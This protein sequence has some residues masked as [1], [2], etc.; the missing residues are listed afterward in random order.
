M[1]PRPPLWL[2]SRGAGIRLHPDHVDSNWD[3]WLD[4]PPGRVSEKEV[5]ALEPIPTGFPG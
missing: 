5:D 1:E 3:R 2:I 4:K